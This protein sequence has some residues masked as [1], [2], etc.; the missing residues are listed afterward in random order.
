[1]TEMF[2]NTIGFWPFL[3]MA[4]PVTVGGLLAFGQMTGVVHYE[5]HESSGQGGKKEEVNRA[6]AVLK[7]GSGVT[8][9]IVF[10]AVSRYT[11]STKVTGE[12]K[13]LKA[14]KYRFL[15]NEF[16]DVSDGGKNT[17]QLDRD[18]GEIE[19]D[20]A[21]VAKI[22]FVDEVNILKI[23]SLLGRSIVIGENVALGVIGRS[24]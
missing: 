1:M 17:G 2:T 10:E 24:K 15:V 9:R 16:G 13:G 18:L 8:G 6:V 21:G 14:G 22:D 23:E 12:V 11:G 3:M 5:K 4:G 19:V 20:N 7:G